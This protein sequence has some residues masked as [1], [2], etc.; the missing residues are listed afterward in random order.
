MYIEE[1]PITV[2]DRSKIAETAATMLRQGYRLVHI[3]CVTGDDLE[4]TYC[5]DKDYK[6]RNFRVSVPKSDPVLPSITASYLAGF[7]YENELQDLFGFKVTDLALNFN[8]TFYRT[9]VKT[10]FNPPADTVTPKA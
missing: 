2:I 3:C 4:V 5:Y 8:G 1:Q 6:T 9:S 10:P 7:T